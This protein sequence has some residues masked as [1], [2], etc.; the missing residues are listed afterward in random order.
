[1]FLIQN[2]AIAIL[3][4]ILCMVCW[5]SWANTQKMVAAKKWS[6][7]L[8]YWDMTWGLFL[9][10]LLAALTLGNM[11]GDGRAFFADLSQAAG[12]SICFA[13]LG[14]IV[15][16]LGTIL[17]TAAMA[18]AG[19]SIGFP[20]GGGLAW[21]GGIVV[22][23]LLVEFS[24]N[25][26]SGNVGMLFI[27]VLCIVIAI[28]L[29]GLAY[30]RL[31]AREKGTPAKGILL[32]L[33]AGVVIMFFYGLVVKSLDPAYVSGGTGNL[34]PYTGVFFFAVGILISTPLFNG[35]AMRHPVEGKVVNWKDYRSGSMRTHLTGVLGGFIW[36]SGMVLS[37]MAAGAANPAI[38]YALSNAAPVVAMLWGIF[39]WKEFRGASKGTNRI[40][41]GMFTLFIVG[42]IIITL[43][44]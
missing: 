10:A 32:S 24:G 9:T 21:V 44:N 8:F 4:C 40:L 41:A 37:F 5:G 22:N 19:M 34:T 35:F 38:S 11:G 13:I 2:Y 18:I 31:T 29:C 43:S 33:C 7:E 26:Y 25:S 14:G 30:K 23:F 17:L 39:V 3:L 36:M 42:L 20:I 16:N 15:W 27:G 12:S 28:L 1:M 6:F